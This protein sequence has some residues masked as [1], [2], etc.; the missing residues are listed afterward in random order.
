[1]LNGNPEVSG[2]TE[3]REKMRI[4]CVAGMV[5]VMCL[6][7]SAQTNSYTVTPIVNNTQDS[8]LVNPW[9]LSRPAKSSISEN[10]WW[11]SDNGT[12]YTTLYYA[13]KTGSQALAPLAIIIPTAIGTGTGTP[14]GTAYNPGKGP[15]PGPNNFAFAT[16][17][18]TISNWNADQ[19]P[20]PGGTGC[21]E[22]H[23]NSATV[24]VNHSSSGASYFGLTIATN[25]TTKA[26]A[27]YAT[28]HNGTVEAYDAASFSPVSLLGT[29]S[30]SMIPAAYKP[31]GIQAIGS[32]VWVTYFNGISGGFVDEFDTTGRLKLRLAQ[33]SFSEPW[34]IAQAP[35]NFGAFSN[36]LLVGNTTSGFIAAFNPTTGAF[37]GFLNDSTGNP[38]AIPGLWGI[39]FGN[40]N[41]E[42]GPVNTL[43]YNGGGVD[44]LTGV[45]GAITAN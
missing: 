17:D 28:N 41:K 2:T 38:I 42:S 32:K 30:D 31:Y 24:E 22:C 6:A 11:V 43:Y 40:G 1:L 4:C 16:L 13:D 29:F 26:A 23:V 45:F 20:A 9:G 35:A 36:M 3:M 14:T 37:Q 8:F 12:G 27:Y 25:A 15:G 34:G 39:S 5:L 7:V 19:K 33:G 10:E 18:G 21:Y 44:Y